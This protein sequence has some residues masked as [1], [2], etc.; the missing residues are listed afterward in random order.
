[1]VIITNGKQKH[2]RIYKAKSL[3][4]ETNLLAKLIE[5]KRESKNNN[6]GIKEAITAESAYIQRIMNNIIPVLKSY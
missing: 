6:L 5:K 3:L 4:F 1:M 2:N